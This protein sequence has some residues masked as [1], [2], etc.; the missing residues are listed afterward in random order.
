MTTAHDAGVAFRA[1]MTAALGT[2]PHPAEQVEPVALLLTGE[3][4]AALCGVCLIELPAAWGC[5]DCQWIEERRLCDPAPRLLLG[6][7]CP[8]HRGT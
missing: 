7:P 2:C 8:A 5:A 3:V 6:Q 1:N 4:I